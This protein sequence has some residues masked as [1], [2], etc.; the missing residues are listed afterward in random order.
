ME[1]NNYTTHLSL[2]E[3]L[4]RLDFITVLLSRYCCIIIYCCC[5]KSSFTTKATNRNMQVFLCK[6]LTAISEEFQLPN[7][8]LV[9]LGLSVTCKRG[10]VM[11]GLSVKQIQRFE[12][13]E[14]VFVFMRIGNWCCGSLWDKGV[15]PTHPPPPHL[16]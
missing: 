1:L 14:R 10:N 5:C 15:Q 2:W 4:G 9:L 8:S 12:L 11:S 16:L 6:M 13:S 3:D 7:V